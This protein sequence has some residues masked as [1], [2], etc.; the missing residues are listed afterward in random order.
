MIATAAAAPTEAEIRESLRRRG[1]DY[2]A[3]CPADQLREVVEDWANTLA[4]PAWSALES[5]DPRDPSE[6]ED[7]VDVLWTDLRPT[8]AAV[9][10]D[11]VRLG[12]RTALQRCEEAI[13]DELTKAGLAFARAYPDAPRP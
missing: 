13:V 1:H 10:R 5:P 6:A 8:E 12:V 7:D 9:L 11:A 4:G 3:D 2:P